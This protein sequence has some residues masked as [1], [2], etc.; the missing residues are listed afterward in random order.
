MPSRD[1][2]QQMTEE[3]AS[4]LQTQIETIE[5]ECDTRLE[6]VEQLIDQSVEQLQEAAQDLRVEVDGEADELK[7]NFHW[8][9]EEARN[10][11]TTT[12]A[13]NSRAQDQDTVKDA[14]EFIATHI[15]DLWQQLGDLS[16]K[17]AELS[18]VADLECRF[19]DMLASVT[20]FLPDRIK[21]LASRTARLEEENQN[22]QVNP[23][24]C[25]SLTIR[26]IA[27]RMKLIQTGL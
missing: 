10:N 5:Y 9:A 4:V 11:Q 12:D 3:E 16:A 24:I 19:K 25:F 1:E 20:K 8:A 13:R 18:H 14:T 27:V 7:E 2:T 23:T 26:G 15:G 6:N 22:L 21:L 17:S